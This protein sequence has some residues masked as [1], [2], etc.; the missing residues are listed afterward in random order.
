M[1]ICIYAKVSFN[2]ILEKS[3]TMLLKTIKWIFILLGLTVVVIAANLQVNYSLITK[4]IS[5]PQLHKRAV[6]TYLNIAIKLLETGDI[7]MASIRKVPVQDDVSTQDVEEAMA[8]IA[9]EKGIREV[10]ILPLSE[11]VEIQLKAAGDPN[12]KQRYLKIFQ[13]CS[14]RTAIQIV[15]YSNAFSAYLPC[16]IALVEDKQGKR[17][18]YT[19]DMDLMIYGGKPLPA[20]LHKK[21]LK[22][23]ATIYAIQDGGAAGDF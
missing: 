3:M 18:L 17:W 9:I 8:S 6:G 2:T 14:P 10:G 21:A 7:A 11:Q 20:E 12:F 1:I 15:D 19:L 22:V 23:Q 13:Y 16:R 4:M 5:A